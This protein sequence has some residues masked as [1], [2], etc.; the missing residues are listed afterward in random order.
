M[1]PSES[2]SFETTS[3]VT[4]I[5]SFVLVTSTEAFGA[6][7]TGVTVRINVSLTQIAGRGVPLSQTETIT[8]S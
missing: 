8:V 4:E 7:F 5:S 1:L 3:I 6:S 2:V